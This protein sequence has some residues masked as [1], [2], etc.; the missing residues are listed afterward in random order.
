MKRQLSILIASLI[1]SALCSQKALSQEFSAFKAQCFLGVPAYNKPLVNE[2]HKTLPIYIQAD[3][4]KVHAT[5]KATFL[6]NVNIEQGNITL[7]AD[8]VQLQQSNDKQLRT[9]TAMGNVEYASNEI[10]L[11]GAK[12]LSNLNTKNIDVYKGNYQMV[13]RQGRGEA[14]TI[15]Q[16]SDNRYLVLENGSF[17]SC[18][19]G[20]NSWS[21]AGSKVIHDRKEQVAEIWNARLKIGNLS[22]LY[23]PYLQLPVGNKRRSGFLIPNAKYGSS[24][25]F[26]FS[27]PY[28]LNLAKNYD[29]TITPK[30]M[31]KW[32]MQLQNEF[33]YLTILGDGLVELDWLPHNQIYSGE[34]S[35]ARASDRWLLYWRHNG[36]IEKVWRVNVDYTKVSDYDYFHNLDSKHGSTNDS[37]TTQKFSIGYANKNWDTALFYKQFQVFDNSSAA[38]LAV[39][40]LDLNFYTN[41][42]HLLDFKF[43]SQ[44][45]KFINI[46]KSYPKATR[47][48]I[49]PTLG[50]PM[51]NSWGSLN[52]EAK[53]MA[54]YYKQEN[55]N[56]YN[57]LTGRHLK[58]TV[59]RILLQLKTDGKIVFKRDIDYLVDYTQTLEPRLQYLYVPYRNQNNIGVYDS[60]MLQTD[61][62]AGMF[63]DRSY[64]GLDRISSANQLAG[65]IMT[66]IY[67]NQRVERVNIS[68]GQIYYFSRPR[69]GDLKG[70]WDRYENTG[71]LVWAGNSYWLINNNWGFR[72][73][74]QYDFRLNSIALGDMVLEYRR[75]E[76]CILQLNYRYASPQYTKHL[77]SNMLNPG[78]QHS[79][80]QVGVTGS[81]LLVNRWS[82]VGTYY[83]D[84]KMNQPA[85]QLI[86]LQYNTCCW[87]VSVGYERK[88]T[89]WNSADSSSKYDKQISCII[90]LRGLSSNPGLH[91][92]TKDSL[93][94][95]W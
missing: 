49:E 15:K 21:V 84:V 47:L 89:G 57:M 64:S 48:H 72:G 9:V 93:A 2:D 37:Y 53:L 7:S 26:E 40:Q 3:K 32:G 52:T 51:A 83:Y 82:L 73:G 50:L 35:S 92:L 66:R 65:G 71:S 31:S 18:L 74:F 41:D 8:Q 4:A 42:V 63:R 91:F 67:D 61:D 33:R 78:W 80:S 19:P 77:L 87:A 34:H 68:A 6:G 14:D 13:G 95:I 60:T 30:Y 90:E 85:N 62:Y 1:W 45:V 25:G 69:T 76:D 22:V 70:T 79:I 86:C 24:N 28:Y 59:N 16:R 94:D 44:A 5:D 56:N 81:W 10:K 36:V 88:I 54:T 43:F 20:D 58:G 27:T 46:N 17:T 38:Y 55:F 23:S 11:K 12:A 29:A 39:P 75:D